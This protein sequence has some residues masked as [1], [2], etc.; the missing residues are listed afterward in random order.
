MPSRVLLLLMLVPNFL[1]CAAGDAPSDRA[2]RIDTIDAVVH[3]A[4]PGEGLWTEE[5]RWKVDET[6]ALVI[7]TLDGPE[8]YVFGEIAGVVASKDGRVYIAD[9]QA[10]EVRIFSEA[11]DLLGRF[12]RD[13]EG[14]GE[15]RDISGLGR[16]PAGGVATLDG[17]L[18]R[19]SVFQSD[20]TFRRSF[21]LERPYVMIRRGSPIRFDA[22]GRFYDQAGFSVRPGVD[23]LGV[24]RYASDG[25]VED[26]V[27]AIIHEPR[28]IML[29]RD[30][31]PV[32]SIPLPFAPRPSVAVGP[33]GRIFAASGDEYRIAELGPEGDTVRVIARTVERVAVGEAEREE[34]R[35][36]VE[37]AYRNATGSAPRDLPRFPEWKAPVETIHVDETGHLWVLVPSPSGSTAMTWDVLDP[38][39]R[40]LGQ[41]A[42]PRM[43][44]MHIG[45]RSVA[46]VVLDEL[47]VPRVVVLPVERG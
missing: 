3:V 26:T 21:K 24:V 4:N 42:L 15:F 16:A 20:G 2:I 47:E 22:A 9:A 10:A 19:V 38:E 41:V 30:G 7:G 17:S 23:T 31:V 5:T 46:G 12:G 45:E 40:F 8:E 34:V 14:P 36:L 27:V 28:Q 43:F 35:A 39:G 29:Q 1:A 32:M 11:G 13:G 6:R 33:D 37:D 44:V 25:S 18:S